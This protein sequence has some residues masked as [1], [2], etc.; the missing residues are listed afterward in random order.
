MRSKRKKQHSSRRRPQRA[1]GRDARH[2]KPQFTKPPDRASNPPILW[3]HGLAAM[4]DERWEEAIVALQRFLE[5][6]NKP[7]DRR[8]AFQNLSACYLAMER[9]DEAL[10]ALDEK[11]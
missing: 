10:A 11:D 3:L 1:T 7:E 5:M 4:G 9:Y 2:R 6:A 8:L